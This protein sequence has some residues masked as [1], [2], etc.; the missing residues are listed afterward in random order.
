MGAKKYPPRY[1]HSVTSEARATRIQ[2]ALHDA[3][4]NTVSVKTLMGRAGL[5]WRAS[6]VSSFVSF[7]NDFILINQEL[8]HVGWQAERSDGTPDAVCRLSPVGDG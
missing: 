7:C 6:P 1:L 2:R 5:S 3:Y 4:P 8:S